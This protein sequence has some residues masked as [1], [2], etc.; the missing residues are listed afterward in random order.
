MGDGFNNLSFVVYGRRQPRVII[1]GDD[2]EKYASIEYVD[3]AGLEL[4]RPDDVE[5]SVAQTAFL[6]WLAFIL[7]ANNISFY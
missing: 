5:E 7:Y 4:G 3:S 6:R 1:E 2:E